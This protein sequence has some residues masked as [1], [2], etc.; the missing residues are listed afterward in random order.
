MDLSKYSSEK[1]N[2]NFKPFNLT[3][4]IQATINSIQPFIKNDGFELTFDHNED[5]IVSGDESSI[6]RVLYNLIQNAINYS[7]T[8]RLVEIRQS[9]DSNEVRIE[10][11]DHGVGIAKEELPYIFDRYYRSSSN[12]ERAIIGSGLGLS[13]VKAILERHNAKFGVRSSPGLGST[14]W[15]VLEITQ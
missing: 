15:F 7:G 13:I 11:I 5:V 2:R 3:D 6:S 14:F 1:T 4:S 9:L 12:H 8:S 10:V